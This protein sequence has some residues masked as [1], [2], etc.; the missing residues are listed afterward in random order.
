MA[1]GFYIGT[2]IIFFV[3]CVIDMMSGNFARAMTGGTVALI[4]IILIVRRG[5]KG[6]QEI[7]RRMD[8][9]AKYEPGKDEA[10]L[11]NAVMHDYDHSPAFYQSMQISQIPM[12][13]AEEYFAE[14]KR[15]EQE[16]IKWIRSGYTIPC[17]EK[18]K[19]RIDPKTLRSPWNQ[20]NNNKAP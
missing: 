5:I 2:A 7:R 12:V 19:L 18:K 10:W 13:S 9:I 8:F 20:N 4:A 6:E 11:R 1:E 3:M 14:E 17:P 16:M 15:Y